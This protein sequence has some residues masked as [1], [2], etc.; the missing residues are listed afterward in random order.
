[1]KIVL[2][3]TYGGFNL[4]YE[5]QA[6]YLQAKGQEAYF[7]ADVS[8]YDDFTKKHHYTLISFADLSKVKNILYIYCSTTYQGD[9]IDHFPED[10]VNFR[11]IDRTDPVL[12]SVVETMGSKA[13]SGRFASLEIQEIPD[14]TLYKIDEY[15]GLEDIITQD[16]DDWIL[17]QENTCSPDIT[18]QI[19]NLWAT[20][21]PAPVN[22]DPDLM[23]RYDK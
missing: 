3:G 17:A 7:Y 21:K 14:N 10:V 1:M 13:A 18:A 11:D 9:K 16:D 23:F 19:Q 12:V 15:D 2:N 20:I 6:L 22:Y 8:S 5:A 4:S